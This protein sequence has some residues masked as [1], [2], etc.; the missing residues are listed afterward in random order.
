[1]RDISLSNG[2]FINTS[3]SSK[4]A[5]VIIN[6]FKDNTDEVLISINE[7]SG[8]YVFV[9]KNDVTISNIDNYEKLNILANF[10]DWF[11][12]QHKDIYQEHIINTILNR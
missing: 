4:P 6:N 10:G 11:Y 2:D 12:E 9:K 7:Y 8:D 3:V 1:M 5:I